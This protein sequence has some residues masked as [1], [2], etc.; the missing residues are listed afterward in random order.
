MSNCNL[1]VPKNALTAQGLVTPYQLSSTNGDRCTM[2]NPNA[3][4]FIEATIIDTDTGNFFIY[5]PLIIDAGTKPLLAPTPI[6]LP[7]NF[8][9][10][11]WFGY[12]GKHKFVF[13][14]KL[15]ISEN[16]C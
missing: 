15:G 13:A 16:M 4:A 2:N 12:N 3:Q 1:L 6:T 8:N 9:I 10:G 5:R 11:I 7:V 14:I